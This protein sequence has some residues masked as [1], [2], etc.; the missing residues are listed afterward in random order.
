MKTKHGIRILTE[1]QIAGL[2]THNLKLYRRKVL[3]K[4][5]IAHDLLCMFCCEVCHEVIHQREA[6]PA[7]AEDIRVLDYLAGACA[8]EWKKR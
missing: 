3:A 4:R 1:E 2:A 7:E 5:Q 6:T 8:R